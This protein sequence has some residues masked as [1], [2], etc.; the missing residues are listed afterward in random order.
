MKSEPINQLVR[1]LITGLAS[2]SMEY[3]LFIV[4]YKVIGLWY[5]ISHISVYFIVFW[6]NFLVNRFW[7]FKS[8][9][10]IR[11]QLFRYGLLFV[12]NLFAATAI[13]FILSEV[14]NISPLISKVLV[15]GM[16]VLWNFILYRKIIFR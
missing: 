16:I 6:F 14:L 13:M 5:I 4:L 7:S 15:M 3:I 1:Y 12:F 8:K 9:N 11:V 10:D 2:F